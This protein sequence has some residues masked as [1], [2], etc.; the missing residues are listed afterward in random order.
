MPYHAP[1][2]TA[3]A[4]STAEP[5]IWGIH[6]TDDALFRNESIIAIG[7]EEMGDLSSIPDNRESFKQKYMSVYPTASSGNVNTC[8]GML[9]RFVREMQIGDIVIH[10]SKAD[11]QIN[12]GRIEGGYAHVSSRQNYTN[13]RKVKWIKHIPRTAF[14]NGA[15]YE[16]GSALTL[17]QIKN[18]AEEFLAT[19][20]QGYRIQSFDERNDSTSADNG[21]TYDSILEQTRAYVLK[22]LRTKFKGYDFEPVVANLLEAMGYSTVVSPHGG[23]RGL[24]IKAFKGEFQVPPRI[25]VQCKSQDSD[26]SEDFV[27]RLKGTMKDGDYGLFVSLSKF[28]KNALDYLSQNPIIRGIDG[29]EFVELFMKH[30]DRLDAEIQSAVPLKMVYVA[31]P[32]AHD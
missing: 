32:Q 27:Q 6:S 2:T 4:P 28:R 11:K 20:E 14:S 10:P 19:L 24:D 15:L 5:R 12:L 22:E 3:N 1:T 25:I 30:Y 23:D 29:D 21:A 7:W 31:A 8:S 17:F 26:I 16:I 13:Q 9:F 18:Y